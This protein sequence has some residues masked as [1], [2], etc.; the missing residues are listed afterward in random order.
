MEEVAFRLGTMMT[1]GGKSS[2]K[3]Q[4]E[5]GLKGCIGFGG[6]DRRKGIIG[7]GSCREE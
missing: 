1:E 2:W 5:L 3:R 7:V 6:W 4:F